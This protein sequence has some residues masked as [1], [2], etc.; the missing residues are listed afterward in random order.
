MKAVLKH[1]KNRGESSKLY[2]YVMPFPPNIDTSIS[3]C[4][5]K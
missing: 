5:G 4:F 1:G 3:Q 2:I